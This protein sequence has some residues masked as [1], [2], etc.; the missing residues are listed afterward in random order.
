MG[1]NATHYRRGQIFMRYC[2]VAVITYLMLESDM[3]MPVQ[4]GM[5]LVYAFVTIWPTKVFPL[6][7]F[8]PVYPLVECIF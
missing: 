4:G 3:L 1:G 5:H 2:I 8:A 6:H 7:F